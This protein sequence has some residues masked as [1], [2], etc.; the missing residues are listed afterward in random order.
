[1]KKYFSP[2]VEIKSL[3]TDVICVSINQEKPVEFD[4]ED[5]LFN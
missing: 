1:M 3:Q 5:R 2:E 4:W